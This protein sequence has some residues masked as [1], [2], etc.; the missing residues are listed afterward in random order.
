MSGGSPG[1]LLATMESSMFEQATAT[2]VADPQPVLPL[3]EIE[4][5]EILRALEYT[6]GDR[7]TAAQMLGIGRTT[8][9]R[10]L[11]SYD[12]D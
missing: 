4:R 12:M 7:S 9:Y 11:K 5:R 6:N 1:G 10:K 2:A 3:A 8:L